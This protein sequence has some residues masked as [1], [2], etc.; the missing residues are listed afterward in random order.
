MG[1][2]RRKPLPTM[3][4]TTG[5]Q[6]SQA[7]YVY[8]V[9]RATSTPT[10][11]LPDRILPGASAPQIIALGPRVWMVASHVPLSIYGSGAIDAHL[12]DI[13][14]V[15]ACGI[16][17]QAMVD[18]CMRSADTV[19]PMKVFTLFTTIERARGVMRRRGM[20]LN[21]AMKQ[22][23]GCVEWGVRVTRAP[24]PARELERKIKEERKAAKAAALVSASALAPPAPARAAGLGTGTAFLAA[25]AQVR[26][27]VREAQAALD[28]H[29]REMAASLDGVTRDARYRSDPS[30]AR[31]AVPVLLDAA[32]LVPRRAES[33]F[34]MQVKLSS[35]PLVERGCRVTVTG[36][37]PAYSF[38]SPTVR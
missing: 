4:E 23:E 3:T 33:R 13:D 17:H 31:L 20:Q 2:S 18:A 32:Y 11:T 27:A 9:V 6:D 7:V 35:R 19:V 34:R 30:D 26:S 8:C 22:V 14:W 37:W 15:G 25:K 12:K 10:V 21:A 24:Q 38:V 36:P 1:S 28:Q 5:S 16:A 29:L